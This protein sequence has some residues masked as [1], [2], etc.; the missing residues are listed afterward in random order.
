[1]NI[2]LAEDDEVSR[3]SICEFLCELGHQVIPCENGLQAWEAYRE[4]LF[5]LVLTDIKMPQMNGINLLQKIKA[6]SNDH[7]VDVIL[8]TG[9]GDLNSAITALRLG[10]SDYLLKPIKV[11]ELADIIQ[12]VVEKQARKQSLKFTTEQFVT[13]EGTITK[14]H[15]LNQKEHH[16]IFTKIIGIGDVGIFSEAMR[17]IFFE[18]LKLHQDR[19]IPVLIEGETGTGKEVIARLIHYGDSDNEPPFIDINCAALTQFVR[20]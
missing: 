16:K 2:L 20:K 14:K 5:N 13:E 11:L 19:D 10:A 6:A 12:R 3:Q 1:M 17:K 15:S 18:T 4:Q 7:E 9:H 8:F